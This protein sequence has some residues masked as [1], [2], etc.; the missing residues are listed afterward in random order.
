MGEN[1]A[2]N[3]IIL[4]PLAAFFMAASLLNLSAQ[5]TAFFY[6]GRLSD[7]GTAAAGV[8]ELRF[9]LFDAAINGNAISVP[10]TNFGVPVTGQPMRGEPLTSGKLAVFILR[11]LANAASLS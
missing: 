10:Q 4:L 5:G 1:P 8:Y 7:N 2:V 6:Q 3:R 11:S 9:A